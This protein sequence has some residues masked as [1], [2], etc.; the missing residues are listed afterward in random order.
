MPGKSEEG[1]VMVRDGDALF[2]FLFFEKEYWPSKIVK[3]PLSGID[4]GRVKQ[5]IIAIFWAFEICEVETEAV[6]M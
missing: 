6:L 1:V 2:L 4:D 5:A 3:L